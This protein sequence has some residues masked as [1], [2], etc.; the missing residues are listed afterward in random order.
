MGVKK[1][2]L[3]EAISCFNAKHYKSCAMILFSLIESKLI[4]VQDVDPTH[5]K[6][7]KVS[8]GAVEKVMKM[9]DDHISEEALFSTLRQAN[10]ASALAKVFEGG[11]DFKKQP[12][13]INRNFLLHGMLHRRVLKRDCIQLFLIL[14]STVIHLDVLHNP[15]Q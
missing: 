13:V 15:K 2:D 10:L 6:W 7:R 12:I 9:T 8:K 11:D 3:T 5:E 1:S 14:H 4:R